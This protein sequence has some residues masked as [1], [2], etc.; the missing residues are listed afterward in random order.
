MGKLTPTQ[1]A[2]VNAV[3]AM[4][5][6][7]TQMKKHYLKASLSLHPNKGGDIDLFQKLSHVKNILESPYQH[8]YQIQRLKNRTYVENLSRGKNTSSFYSSSNGNNMSS[9]SNGNNEWKPSKSSGQNPWSSGRKYRTRYAFPSENKFKTTRLANNTF[10]FI[11]KRIKETNPV[12]YHR[13]ILMKIPARHRPTPP[14]E[15]SGSQVLKLRQS[16]LKKAIREYRMFGDYYWVASD[17]GRRT[18]ALTVLALG[19]PKLRQLLL[20][21]SKD[22]GLDLK[23]VVVNS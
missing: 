21:R 12:E 4:V 10:E 13:Q 2:F 16:D 15:K 22:L 17:F 5:K 14:T 8:Q 3:D 9:N 23:K 6:T 1:Q 20:Q 11:Y 18:V 19:D 7:P